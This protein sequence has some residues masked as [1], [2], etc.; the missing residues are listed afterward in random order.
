MVVGV[1]VDIMIRVGV[2]SENLG[3]D[4]VTVSLY[5]DVKERDLSIC[6]IFSVLGC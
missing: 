4:L 6:F 3:T 2:V 1:K 5:L